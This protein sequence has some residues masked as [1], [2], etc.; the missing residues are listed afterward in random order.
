LPNWR[1]NSDY[2]KSVSAQKILG[3]GVLLELSH[4][5]DY[6]YWIF[7]DVE[8][9]KSHLSRQSSLEIDVEDVSSN[10]I[11]FK[12][13]KLPGSQLIATLNLDFI[14]HDT[15]RQC[16]AIGDNGSLRWDG[17]SEEVSYF[18]KN[19]KKWGI[20]FDCC[21][22]RDYT[23]I[24]EVEHFF[25]SIE[26]RKTPLISGEDGLKVLKIVEAARKSN[27]NGSIANVKESF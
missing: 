10:I 14:R 16:V 25:N 22:S 27:N 23:Y 24:K 7:G 18:P 17:I 26:F 5:I 20:I 13:G 12:D 21:T 3:G 19:G 8:W 1:P 4:E 15:T 2:K 6:L 9:V 11:G